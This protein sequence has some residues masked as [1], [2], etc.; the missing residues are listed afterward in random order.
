[1]IP[2]AQLAYTSFS[3]IVPHNGETMSYFYIV[4]PGFPSGIIVD[5]FAKKHPIKLLLINTLT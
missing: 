3:E 2:P 5:M 4:T 1:L